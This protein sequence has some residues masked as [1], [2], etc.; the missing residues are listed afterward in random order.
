MKQNLLVIALAL[1]VGACAAPINRQTAQ[2]YFEAGEVA[3]ARGNLPHAEEMFSRALVN[4]RLG[5]MGPKTEGRVL[6]KLGRVYGNECK[7]DQAEE[8]FLLAIEAYEKAQ[9]S[10]FP[11][12]LELGQFSYD[13]G[14]FEAAVG[15][16][17]QAFPTGLQVLE[18][19][20][21]PGYIAVLTDYADALSRTGKTEKAAQAVEKAETAKG[22]ASAV[23]LTQVS[24]YVRYP[25]ECKKL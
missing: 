1:L 11:A 15:Y 3:L 10:V 2:N 16:F 24:E 23:E 19:I 14:R 8:A 12:R 20:D 22:K 6:M 9:I 4:V 25:K 17:E 21:P 13:V 7:Y 18:A 5:N